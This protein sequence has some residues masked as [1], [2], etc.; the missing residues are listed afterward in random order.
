MLTEYKKF[1]EKRDYFEDGDLLINTKKEFDEQ[2]EKLKDS[3]SISNH[4]FRG[5]SEAKYKLYTSSQR[6]WIENQ[7]QTQGISYHN[8]IDKLINNCRNWNHNT[9]KIFFKGNGI[10]PN[11]ALAYL[12]YLQ[13]CGVPTPLLDFTDNPFIGLFFAVEKEIPISSKDIID[14]YCSLYKVNITNKYFSTAI[15]QF[16]NEM[17][18][19]EIDYEEHLISHPILLVS[20]KNKSYRI[21]NNVNIS[22]QEGLFFYNNDALK[23]IEE[24]Y[25][26][27]IN[28]ISDE[29]V[30]DKVNKN[31]YQ[32]KFASCFNIYKNL[33]SYVL[34]KL[35]TVDTSVNFVY[36]DN[37]QI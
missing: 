8:L 14:Q 15:K 33:R 26:D 21:I 37:E 28:A 18:F 34:H 22:N 13:H 11:N 9:L 19:N 16:H 31:N 23:P 12:S 6:Y 7:L 35:T 17:K 20:E 25:I 24:V 30:E 29:L 36:P 2:F 10:S 3:K 5:C 27:K 4:I 1:D 32:T